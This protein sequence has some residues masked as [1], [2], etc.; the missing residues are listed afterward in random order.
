MLHNTLDNTPCFKYQPHIVITFVCTID[1]IL[2]PHRQLTEQPTN[3]FPTTCVCSRPTMDMWRES[4]AQKPGHWQIWR[5]N[6]GIASKW[7]TRPEKPSNLYGDNQFPN[8]G[9]TSKS[10][11]D[12]DM[13]RAKLSKDTTQRAGQPAASQMRPSRRTSEQ[14]KWWMGHWG[15]ECA[16]ES[17][18]VGSSWRAQV[19]TT[20]WIE[21]NKDGEK[22]TDLK[23]VRIPANMCQCPLNVHHDS[24]LQCSLFLMCLWA[25]KSLLW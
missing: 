24:M 10:T 19:K 16:N 12:C 14:A 15:P 9:E 13:E 3:L 4:Y 23:L 8:V 5:L 2:S 17:S 21:M 1:F 6:W 22:R 18:D 7:V 11:S 20:N 25:P